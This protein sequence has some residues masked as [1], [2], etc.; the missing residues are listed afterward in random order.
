MEVKK[1][2]VSFNKAGSG[3]Y[4][5]KLALPA[6]IIKDMGISKDDRYVE[7]TYDDEKKEIKLK[8]SIDK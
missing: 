6:R 5:P 1:L 7:L 8:K 4:T 2:K 3:S